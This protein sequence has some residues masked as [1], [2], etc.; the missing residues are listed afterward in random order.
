MSTVRA[1]R[2]VAER[3]I[4][5]EWDPET[6]E[7]RFDYVDTLTGADSAGTPVSCT[8]NRRVHYLDAVAIHR[9]A[10]I[11]HRNDLH[12]VALWALGND[13]PLTWDGLR[14]ARL[15]VETWND[16]LATTATSAAVP[17]TG[18]VTPATGG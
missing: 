4:V 6:M 11:A 15:G 13:D 12:G 1:A 3:G 17:A 10:W 18:S 5:P 7:R 16:P 2:T 14:A 9:R 8:V